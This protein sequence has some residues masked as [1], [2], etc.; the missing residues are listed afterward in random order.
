MEMVKH[1]GASLFLLIGIG[2]G[3]PG[4]F[5]IESMSVRSSGGRR[6]Q[7]LLDRLLTSKAPQLRMRLSVLPRLA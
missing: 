7:R 3:S 5:L 1:A 6:R 4:L 2:S